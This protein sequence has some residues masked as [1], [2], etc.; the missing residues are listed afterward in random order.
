MNDSADG[1]PVFVR[2]VTALVFIYTFLGA[3][4]YFLFGNIVERPLVSTLDHE[5]WLNFWLL[6]L[7]AFYTFISF[8]V[9]QF[10]WPLGRRPTL[11][12]VLILF[13]MVATI[14]A[15][16]APLIRKVWLNS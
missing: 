1:Y 15:F 9:G 10:L 14:L 3:L 12:R 11:A 2:T 6:V 13:L 8:C 7:A 4:Y 5:C 16:L